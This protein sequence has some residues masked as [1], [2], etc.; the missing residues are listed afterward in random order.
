MSRVVKLLGQDVS[1]YI[2]S[3][4]AISYQQSDFGQI[5]IN[6]ITSLV[7]DNR[8]GFWDIFN[9][10]S[11]FYNATDYT[12]YPLEIF[13][14][15]VSVFNGTIQSLE[16]DYTARTSIVNVKSQLQIALERGTVYA[17]IARDT[18][19]NIVKEICTFYNITYDASSF[20]AAN[21]IYTLNN[22]LLSAL[23]QGNSTIMAAI[24]A[25][26][27]FGVARIYNNRNILFMDAY[28]IPTANPIQTFSNAAAGVCTLFSNP[29][30][31]PIEKQKITGY[32]IKWIGTTGND[33]AVRGNTQTQGKTLTG[34]WSS[35]VRIMTGATAVWIGEQYY[36]YLNRLQS[37]ISFGIPINYGKVLELGYPIGLNY[38]GRSYTMDITAI[39]NS[40]KV[41]S[42][43]TGVTR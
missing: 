33:A 38:K 7:G 42:I 10:A 6:D 5:A 13:N 30:F 1:K 37:R 31:Q 43:V 3:I 16:A 32:N 35:P 21:N 23:F 41:Q 18:P 40:S 24:Q 34:D 26:A 20:A 28:N 25:L 11:P 12:Q 14:D 9:P 36:A 39:D 29:K 17:S 22:V 4:P 2:V 15:G 8:G 27:E 19:A